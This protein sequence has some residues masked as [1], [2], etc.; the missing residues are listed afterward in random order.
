MGSKQFV[1]PSMKSNFLQGG[2]IASVIKELQGCVIFSKPNF[3][4]HNM[5]Y[6]LTNKHV[7]IET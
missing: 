7:F 2:R 3:I 1:L 6:G 5:F 4:I